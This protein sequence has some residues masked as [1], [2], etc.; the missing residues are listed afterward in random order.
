M[1]LEAQ[2]ELAREIWVDRNS[3]DVK[4]FNGTRVTV[5]REKLAELMR[6]FG[7]N[8]RSLTPA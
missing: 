4:N 7:I 6:S 1:K 2:I 8:A 3:D 5:D